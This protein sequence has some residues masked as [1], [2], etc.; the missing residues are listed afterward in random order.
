MLPKFPLINN[1]ADFLRNT[2]FPSFSQIKKLP[3]VLSTKEKKGVLLL[4]VVFFGSFL[5]LLSNIY[6]TYT[7]LTPTRGG[8]VTEGMIGSPRFLNPVYA[9]VND[10]D[11]SLSQLIFSGLLRYDNTGNLISDL[12]KDYSILEG[13]RIFEVNLKEDVRW[14][15]GY[16]FDADDVLF[17]VQTIQDP[18]YKSPVRANWVGVNIQKISPTKIR[19]ILKDP[20]ASF[21]ERLTLKIIPKHIWE[22]ISPEN[23]ALSI[24]NLQPVGTGPYRLINVER[25]KSGSVS[26]VELK[27]NAKYHLE[28]PYIAKLIFKFFATEE[29]LLRTA[30]AG[31]LQSFSLENP[32]PGRLRNPAL[33][34]YEFSIP[35]SYSLF[36]N[37]ESN[38]PI[39]EQNIREALAVSL[40]QE[41]LNT[42]IFDGNA[43]LLSSLL[44]PD[45]FSFPAPPFVVKN[46]EEALALF[47][48]EGYQKTESGDLV[49]VFVSSEFS[50]DLRQGNQGP[51]VTALQECL[52]RDP[53]VY[54]L[55]TT[56]G[57]FGPSTQKAVI[58][59]QEKYAEDVLAPFGLKKGTGTVG[60]STRDKLN[61]LCS[62]AKEDAPL[63]LILTTL[64]QSPL[65]D[66]ASFIASSWEEL[67]I[68]TEIN[69]LAPGEMERDVLKPRNFEVLLFGEI[70]SRVPDPLPFWH[71]SQTKDPGLNLSGYDSAAADTLL[72]Q[73]RRTLNES[74]RSNFLFQLQE[75]LSQDMPAIALYDLPYQYVATKDIKG[76]AG[77]LLSEPS[78]RFSG[79]LDWYIKTKRV[80]NF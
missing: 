77:Q 41:E 31:K 25:T 66:V 2:K 9:Q 59:F 18:R 53:E 72:E 24:Y 20:F 67:G 76:I 73:I 22:D 3:L 6:M 64:D 4:S 29:E 79:I 63:R 71:S 75:L 8:T 44:R 1:L 17:T 65:K 26:E 40:D 78:Q 35:R 46:I 12:A 36:F 32:S 60:P 70:L 51:L 30:D 58:T 68:V 69:L 56:N 47:G 21:P 62:I 74:E 11:R 61:E 28:G 54:P 5:F 45:L 23:F 33:K 13:G 57:V 14:H 50:K 27:I 49:K 15:D 52:A 34:I 37:L 42:K 43:I 55:G 38:S 19:F 10:V 16:G 39:T 48:K 80:W 7:V